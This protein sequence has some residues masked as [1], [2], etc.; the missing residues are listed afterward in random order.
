MQPVLEQAWQST[1]A[2]L[3]RE[4]APAGPAESDTSTA[5]ASP[6]VNNQFNVSIAIDGSPA[7]QQPELQEQLVNLLRDAARRQGLDV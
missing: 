6:R 4:A 5:A 1:N 2:S 3:L 7:S